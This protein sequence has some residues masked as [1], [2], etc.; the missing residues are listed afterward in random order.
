M[1]VE[2]TMR[3][4]TV[5]RNENVHWQGSMEMESRRRRKAIW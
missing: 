1:T 3:E 4:Y 5:T 2:E